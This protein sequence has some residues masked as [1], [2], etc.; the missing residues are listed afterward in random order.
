VITIQLTQEQLEEVI[1]ACS[2][3]GWENDDFASAEMTLIDALAAYK[4]QGMQ[5]GND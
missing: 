3:V 4:K 1:L 2:L 5:H